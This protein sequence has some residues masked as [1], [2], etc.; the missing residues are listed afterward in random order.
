MKKCNENAAA[1]NA[2]KM[3]TAKVAILVK[4][5]SVNAAF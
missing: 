3:Y 4:W 1:V 5:V 2:W